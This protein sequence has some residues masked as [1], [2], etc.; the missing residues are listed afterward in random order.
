MQAHLIGGIPVTEVE[1]QRAIFAKFDLK[2]TD[3]FVPTREGYYDFATVITDKAAIKTT[4][5]QLPAIIAT[6]NHINQHLQEWW[7][8]ARDDFAKL[9]GKQQ[10]LPQVRKELLTSLKSR[11]LPLNVFDEYQTA[12]IFVNWWQTIR[13][14]LKTIVS[15]GW[16]HGLIPDEYLI[17]AFFQADADQIAT[18]ET[19]ISEA[20]SELAEAIESVDYEA[21]ENEAEN[22]SASVIKAF[23]K[24]QLD[25]LK[26]SVDSSAVAERETY[27][28]Q[29]KAIEKAESKLKEFKAQLKTAQQTL[30]IKVSIKRIGADEEIADTTALLKQLELLLIEAENDKK[31]LTALNKDKARLQARL[32]S[33]NALI[34][35]VGESLT[36][37]EAKQL[38]L[39]KLYDLM[40]SELARYLNAEKRALLAVLENWFDKYAVSMQA[41]EQQRATTLTE[42]NGFL[43][44]LG[45]LK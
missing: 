19:K 8:I 30:E 1:A 13:Y 44:S 27:H 34:V 45:Y 40:S 23:L 29:Q 17:A 11:L 6:Q 32:D 42:L 20:Q 9:H 3:V 2:I 10:S 36:E 39:K 4:V 18:L 43:T 24:Q 33:I 26:N 7:Q 35:E 12:G 25:D 15:T 28:A 21:D 37:D 14:D 31:R 16:H 41:L 5:E 38:I 22:I